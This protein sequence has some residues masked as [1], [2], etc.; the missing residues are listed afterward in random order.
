MFVDNKLM[1][2]TCFLKKLIVAGINIRETRM[3]VGGVSLMSSVGCHCPRSIW[4]LIQNKAL[5]AGA[6]VYLENMFQKIYTI[7]N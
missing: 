4:S 2:S 3:G 5:N 7:V 6:L 1:P